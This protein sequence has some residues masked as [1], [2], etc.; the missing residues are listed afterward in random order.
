M[1]NATYCNMVGDTVAQYR[2][3]L[4]SI[5]LKSIWKEKTGTE[6]PR[7]WSDINKMPILAM[8]PDTELAECRIVFGIINNP[9]PS[10]KDIDKA[11]TYLD[12]FTHWDELCDDN[13]KDKAF[14]ERFLVDMS[15]LLPNAKEVRDYIASHT[16]E[17]AYSW[18]GNPQVHGLIEKIAEARYNAIGCEKA[19]HNIDMMPADEVKKYLKELIKNNMKVGIQILKNN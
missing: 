11:L 16:T 3:E 2:K 7:K 13:A 1:D 19:I 10:D 18:M 8:L 4:G 15:V 17:S 6:S 12:K 14:S 9:N 5:R